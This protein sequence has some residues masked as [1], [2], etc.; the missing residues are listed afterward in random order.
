[1]IE[2]LFMN[3][4]RYRYNIIKIIPNYINKINS[5]GI[6]YILFLIKLIKCLFNILEYFEKIWN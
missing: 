3:I 1:M 4:N 6:I 5:L 2:T